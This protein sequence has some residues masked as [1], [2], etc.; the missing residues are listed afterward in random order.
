MPRRPRIVQRAEAEIDRRTAPDHAGRRKHA[1]RSTGHN[2]PPDP[3][4]EVAALRE[5]QS[6]ENAESLHRGGPEHMTSGQWRGMVLGGLVGAVIGALLALPLALVPFMDPAWARM[7]L[8]GLCGALAGAAASGVYWAG[9]LPELEG[10]T[11]DVEGRPSSGSTL[12]DPGTDERG[13]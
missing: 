4:D 1:A 10:E 8:V 12:R 13:R 11:L 5:E 7:L 2:P 3:N 6:A 9:R